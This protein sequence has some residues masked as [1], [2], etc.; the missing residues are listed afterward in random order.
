MFELSWSEIIV[1]LLV[2]LIVIGPKEMPHVL[3]KLKKIIQQIN[4][5][6]GDI[7]QSIDCDSHSPSIKQVAKDLNHELGSIKD[8]HGNLQETY[9]LDDVESLKR[10]SKDQ[11]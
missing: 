3:R 6:A 2:C 8:L 10:Q 7:W 11:S 1:L 9:K 4:S 5:Q